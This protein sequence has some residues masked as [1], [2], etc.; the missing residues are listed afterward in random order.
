[1]A[2]MS[3]F[4]RRLATSGLGLTLLGVVGCAA[5]DNEKAAEITSAPLK[6]PAPTYEG[7]YQNQAAQQK[8][9]FTKGGGY[10]GAGSR[11]SGS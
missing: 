10:P 3:L 6:G 7:Y 5:E 2:Q 11:S 4:A 1:M 8:K 9:M